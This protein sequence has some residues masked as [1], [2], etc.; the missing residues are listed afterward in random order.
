MRRFNSPPPENAVRDEF[1]EI[2][3]EIR[4]FRSILTTSVLPEGYVYDDDGVVIDPAG[5]PVSGEQGPAGP[6]G[7]AGPSG[8]AGPAGANGAPG[9]PGPAGADG[10]P[11]PAG[12]AGPPGPAGPM[13]PG[14]V[15]IQPT[16]PA[17]PGYNYAWFQTEIG[18]GNDITIW[19]EDG[20]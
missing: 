12:P 16:P 9:A 14:N 10:D 2:W 15:F 19:I 8:P 7:P 20:T 18:P 11:G 1:I 17:D 5:D 13:G 3:E 6:A 4:R